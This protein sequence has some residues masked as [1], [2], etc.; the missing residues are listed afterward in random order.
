MSLYLSS[1]N[2][3]A[4]NPSPICD[5]PL[6]CPD[7]GENLGKHKSSHASEMKDLVRRLI[8]GS[9]ADNFVAIIGRLYHN[10]RSSYLHDG[11]LSGAEREGGF[12]GDMA[13][14]DPHHIQ[15]VEDMANVEVL[16]RVLLGLFLQDRAMNQPQ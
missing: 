1:I 10:L 9:G 15:L 14:D 11:L 5:S 7:C 4:N 8:T 13:N 2:Q 3:L 16:N 12:L 6:I